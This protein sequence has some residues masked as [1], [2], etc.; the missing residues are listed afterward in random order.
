MRL[1]GYDADGDEIS[2]ADVLSDDELAEDY[3]RRRVEGGRH[4][5]RAPRPSPRRVDEDGYDQDG[6]WHPEREGAAS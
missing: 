1:A 5:F 3:A 6:T 2:D 4:A